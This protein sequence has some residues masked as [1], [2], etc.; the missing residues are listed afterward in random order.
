MIAPLILMSPVFTVVL[1][2]LLLG[3]WLDLRMIS[4]R[5]SGSLACCVMLRGPAY[6]RAHHISPSDKM[7]GRRSASPRMR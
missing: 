6:P 7:S 3:D 4:A 5:R 2:V 1:G